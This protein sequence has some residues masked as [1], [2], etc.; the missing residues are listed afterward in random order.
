MERN[1]IYKIFIIGSLIIYTV[2]LGGAVCATI[3]GNQSESTMVPHSGSET[4][5][6]LENHTITPYDFNFN[7]ENI[8][9][10]AYLKFFSNYD[11]DVIL[12][13]EADLARENEDI[14]ENY[15]YSG[16]TH[17]IV[18]YRSEN[19]INE[20]IPLGASNN[21]SRLYLYIHRY[22]KNV[23]IGTEWF[24]D[25]HYYA[26]NNNFPTEIA[27]FI[28]IYM[29]ASLAIL[30]MVYALPR[31]ISYHAEEFNTLIEKSI[32]QRREMLFTSAII[33]D[34]RDFFC[35]E[36]TQLYRLK[37][38]RQYKDAVIKMGTIIEGL[39]NCW[40]ERYYP[41]GVEIITGPKEKRKVSADKIEFWELIQ[42]M[43][44][45]GCKDY[46]N[47]GTINEWN[48]IDK[49]VRDYRNCIHPTKMLKKPY[50]FRKEE[51]ENLLHDFEAIIEKIS[52][53]VKVDKNPI[54][55]EI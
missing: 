51:F 37:E 16:I 49:Y 21:L 38:L 6:L 34:K 47:V 15:Y 14:N 52:I 23:T 35:D 48:H 33:K 41:A 1:T 11:C 42:L 13:T 8:N 45:H 3:W 31:S 20:I 12:F 50:A 24:L 7:R 54:E 53:D 32:K 2:G 22:E 28:F 26:I 29:I 18:K 40:V 36:Y 25:V 39:L 10:T 46:P 27:L 55:Y 5:S 9:A 19:I 4:L 44:Q 30:I 43:I 17:Y